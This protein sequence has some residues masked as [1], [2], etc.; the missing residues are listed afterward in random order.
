MMRQELSDSQ[1][2]PE[3][4]RNARADISRHLIIELVDVSVKE[5]L[6]SGQIGLVLGR[7]VDLIEAVAV[8]VTVIDGEEHPL[9]DEA[10]KADERDE[11]RRQPFRVDLDHLVPERV[12]YIARQWRVVHA[13]ILDMRQ[14]YHRTLSIIP[15]A[16]YHLILVNKIFYGA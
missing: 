6:S 16:I 12:H 13:A 1:N 4:M 10:H 15:L 14:T 3:P 5:E 2:K 9:N 11:V 7:T 8:E